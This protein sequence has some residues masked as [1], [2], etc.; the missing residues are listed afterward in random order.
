MKWLAPECI[1]QKKFTHFSDIWSYGVLVWE[2]F[3]HGATPYAKLTAVEAAMS[4][5]IGMRLQ[6]PIG[7]P[8]GLYQLMKRMWH[9]D[10]EQRITIEEVQTILI[11]K[12]IRSDI[13]YDLSTSD[14]ALSDTT[15]P[16]SPRFNAR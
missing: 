4:I 8:A 6:Q 16:T 12:L 15:P 11:N 13:S 2:V 9:L 3:A 1:K 7:C 10:P 5:G 14:S